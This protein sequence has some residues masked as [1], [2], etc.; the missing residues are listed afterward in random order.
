MMEFPTPGAQRLRQG[1]FVRV[2][3]G[4]F[5]LPSVMTKQG[6]GDS[7]DTEQRGAS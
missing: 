7:Q 2:P 6:G 4:C 3:H 1:G 5:V